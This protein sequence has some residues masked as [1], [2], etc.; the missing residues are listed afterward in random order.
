MP[1]QQEIDSEELAEWTAIIDG[2]LATITRRLGD[3]A[4]T[5][6][7]VSDAEREIR[8]SACFARADS[9]LWGRDPASTVYAAAE[10]YVH[11]V[12]DHVRS[13]RALVAAGAP[14]PA[15]VDA[16]ARAALE[17]TSTIWWLTDDRVSARKRVARLYVVRRESAA[18]YERAATAMGV[19]PDG[20][21]GKTLADL[22]NY[23]VDQLGLSVTLSKK[24]NWAGS[25]DERLPGPTHR[26]ADYLESIGHPATSAVYNFLSGSAHGELWRLQYGYTEMTGSDGVVRQY[27][28]LSREFLRIGIGVALECLAYAIRMPLTMLGRSAALNDIWHHASAI[29]SAF[30]YTE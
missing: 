23:Y 5:P 3:N 25:E 6:T 12:M 1:D 18:E 14:A 21:Y 30:R 13:L 16:L 2:L 9:G 7:F 22:D 15:S 20:G 29:G 27:Q 11:V 4:W 10:M 8:E 17:A 24:K 19:A 26:V 28:V